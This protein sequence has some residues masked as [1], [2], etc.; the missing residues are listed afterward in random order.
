[1]SGRNQLGEQGKVCHEESH[2][3]DLSSNHKRHKSRRA[4]LLPLHSQAK[5][6]P[7]LQYST[8]RLNNRSLSKLWGKKPCLFNTY[9]MRFRASIASV[10]TFYSP[11]LVHA[12]RK[13]PYLTCLRNYSGSRK[14]SETMCHKIYGDRHAYNLCK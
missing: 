10:D 5:A 4:L 12:F 2:T 1:M 6:F 7:N 9:T 8:C 11:F 14:T 13:S 3:R